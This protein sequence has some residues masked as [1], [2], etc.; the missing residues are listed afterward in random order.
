MAKCSSQVWWSAQ[1]AMGS[2]S[3]HWCE[4][5][6]KPKFIVWKYMK[7]KLRLKGISSFILADETPTLHKTMYKEIHTI[8]RFIL[9]SSNNVAQIWELLFQPTI[10]IGKW[11]QSNSSFR[12]KRSK[13]SANQEIRVTAALVTL[14]AFCWFPSCLVFV[15]V[16]EF[17]ALKPTCIFYRVISEALCM[18]S[19]PILRIQK[20]PDVGI[21][22]TN[23]PKHLSM[24]SFC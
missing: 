21:K 20:S 2:T 19:I 14:S 13:Y 18:S 24:K 15:L 11:H 12:L 8:L 1:G 7:M 6:K 10:H 3:T 9:H 17:S 4:M 22:L 16:S 5:R 23:H